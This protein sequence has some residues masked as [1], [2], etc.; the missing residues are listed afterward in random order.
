MV[1]G[2]GHVSLADSQEYQ[3]RGRERTIY[4]NGLESA[5]ERVSRR[6]AGEPTARSVG[7]REDH[8]LLVHA[9]SCIAGQDT[10]TQSRQLTLMVQSSSVY[11][12]P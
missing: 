9:N 4:M 5:S 8:S 6:Y 10:G 7:G 3:Q 1:S 11:P 2:A 12:A